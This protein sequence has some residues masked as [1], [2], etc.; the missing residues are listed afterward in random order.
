MLKTPATLHFEVTNACNNA[1][2]HCYASSWLSK[3]HANIT[4]DPLDV[5]EAIV[6]NDVFDVVI[7][8]GEPLMLGIDKLLRIM[9]FFN[10]TNTKFSLNTNARLLTENTCRLLK[11]CN[12]K[13][14]LVSLHSWDDSL[15]DEFVGRDGAAEATKKGITNAL[16]NGLRVTVNQ[17]ISKENI[18]TMLDTCLELE[19]MGVYGVSFTRLISP[20]GVNYKMDVVGAKDFIDA[21]ETCRER[22][23]I[24]CKNLI[25]TPYCADTRVKDLG[26]PLCCTGGISTAAVSCIGEVRFCPQDSHV[27]GNLLYE[28]LTEIWDRIVQWRRETNIPKE[29][30][31]C[32]FLPDC[33]GGC[34]VASKTYSGDYSAL[35]P[36]AVGPVTDYE[37][38]VIYHPFN[39][40]STHMIMPNIRYRQKDGEYLLYWQNKFIKVNEDGFQLLQNLP[41]KFVPRQVLAQDGNNSLIL[42]SFLEDMYKS[43]LIV[44]LEERSKS[45]GQKIAREESGG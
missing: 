11:N 5:A 1:C 15:H 45:N 21:Y 10:K 12:P 43:E 7:T 35:D 24:P 28:D 27:W 19:K 3:G 42:M 17:V 36:W 13:G 29:C 2:R 20:L 30:Q 26:E 40:S 4:V 44:E 39:P 8:G 34:R 23:G 18:H 31:D 41:C 9:D 32:V 22:V 14:V 38:K 37:R 33:K 25:P 16:K 6:K